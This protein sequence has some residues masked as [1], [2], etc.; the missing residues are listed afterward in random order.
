MNLKNFKILYK[1]NSDIDLKD[2]NLKEKLVNIYN[3]KYTLDL[4]L[5]S[6]SI[7]PHKDDLEFYID[8][9]NLKLYGSQGQQR[10]AVLALKLAEIEIFKNYKNSTP[11][12]LLDDIF[13]EIDS[14]K[15]NNLLKYINKNIQTIITT[16]DLNDIDE[17][18]IKNAKIFNVQEGKI[19]KEV[20]K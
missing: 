8:D 20:I 15:K 12:L 10:V 13:S 1:N 6:T 9:L 3:D 11:I 5:T 16:T 4:K 7:G 17:S 14:G 18:I 2:P 19:T